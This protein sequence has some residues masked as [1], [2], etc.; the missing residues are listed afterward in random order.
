MIRLSRRSVLLG[1]VALGA[2]ALLPPARA[3]T[4]AGARPPLPI[5]PELRPDSAG[6]IVLKAQA[7]TMRF[8]D[9]AVTPTY[10]INGPYLGPAL[11]LRRGETVAMEVENGLAETITM[12][13]HGLIIPGEADGGPHNIIAPGATWRPSLA[14][15]QP[16]ATLWYHPHIYPATAELVVRGLA[17]MLVIDEDEAD[18]LGLPARWGVDDIPVV[19]QDRR[20][21]PDGEIFHRFNMTAITVGYVGDVALVNGARHPEARTARGWLRLRILNGS[22]AR[23][24]RLAA[25]DGRALHVVASDGGLLESPVE[26]KELLVHVGERYEVLVDARDGSAFDLV[27]LPVAQPIMRLPPFDAPLPLVTFTPDGADGTGRL[28]DAL[29]TLPALPATLPAVSQ[30]LVMDMNRDSEGMALLMKAGLPMEMPA[31]GAGRAGMA[32]M[33]GMGGMAGSAGTEGPAGTA[34][35]GGMAGHAGAAGQ[36]GMAGHAGVAKG[37]GMAEEATTDPAVVAR[38]VDLIV[39]GAPLPE[40]EQL[41]ANGINGQSFALGMKG[42]SAAR[43]RELRWR[44]AEGTDQMLHPVH[45]HGCQFRIVSLDGKAPPAHLAGWKDTAAIEAGGAAEILV[46]FPHEAPPHAPYMAHCHILEHEDSG[47]M[48][49]FSVG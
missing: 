17:G 27:T 12:H 48:T 40:A 31:G 6:R 25:S 24:Y 47:M 26:M 11:R 49:Q 10:G 13:W 35:H 45:V 39:N 22:N 8:I 21:T 46:T 19:I 16:A 37:G 3:A 5:P 36:P 43:G 14:I 20:F 32:G 7:G 1:G 41:G 44:I 15:D 38:L 4:H 42:F 34:G 2:A 33:A 9:S 30:D 29:A 28:P 18:G 23:S